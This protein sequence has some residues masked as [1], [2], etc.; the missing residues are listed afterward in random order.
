MTEA[1]VGSAFRQAT[2]SRQW[3]SC[4]SR[5]P[6]WPSRL[7]AHTVSRE[8]PEV[9]NLNPHS[10]TWPHRGLAYGCLRLIALPF[11]VHSTVCSPEPWVRRV[12]V[13]VP[14][15]FCTCCSFR[16]IF[17]TF[18]QLLLLFSA[19]NT[20]GKFSSPFS[21]PVPR[22]VL[23]FA[24]ACDTLPDSS[25]QS[26]VISIPPATSLDRTPLSRHGV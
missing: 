23:P 3:P 19:F 22:R 8:S 12:L 5:P 20:S 4:K 6:D 18:S 10:V 25:L 11:R 13:S 24:T 9:R 1:A 21:F 26:P 15:L 2:C 14:P 16:R 7:H 17:N